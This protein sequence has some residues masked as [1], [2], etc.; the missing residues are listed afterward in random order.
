[1][2]VSIEPDVG[3]EQLFVV[4]LPDYLSAGFSRRQEADF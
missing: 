4:L 1:M 3:Q 2:Y